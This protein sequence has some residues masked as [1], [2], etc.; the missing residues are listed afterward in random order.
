MLFSFA[1]SLSVLCAVFLTEKAAAA[2]ELSGHAKYLFDESMSFLDQIYDPT[3]GY[4]NYF[5]YP[6]AANRHETRS[7]MWY[8]AGLLQRN[9]GTDADE[10]VKIIT[11]I[12]GGQ[13]KNVSAQWYGDYTKYPEEP[14]VGSPA[15]EPVVSSDL[16]YPISKETNGT[17]AIG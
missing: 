9:E 7:S 5:Y 16:M 6:L 4:L 1:R 12:I 3:A 13:N 8:A 10:A 2:S 14:T 15:Y 17:V 11:N